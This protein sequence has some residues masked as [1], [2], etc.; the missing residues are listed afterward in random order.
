ML[1]HAYIALGSN[2]GDRRA[3]LAAA[4]AALAATNGIDILRISKAIE[5]E[6]VGCP[7]GS[8]AFLN[9]ALAL[10]T[11]LSAP[12]LLAALHYV[13]AALGRERSVPNAPR[14]IDLDLLLFGD[15]VYDSPEITVPHPRLHERRFVLVPLAEIAG[16]VAH[17]KLGRT[18]A[19]LLAD[20][21]AHRSG[22]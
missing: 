6:P 11:S 20:L 4:T 9:S 13:E 17:P 14:V 22:S 3:N 19:Q 10:G 15:E 21:D 18:I 5:T 7:P 2:V 16:D 12:A 1:R 8:G